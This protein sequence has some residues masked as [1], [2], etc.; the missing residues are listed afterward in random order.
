MKLAYVTAYDADDRSKWSGLGYYLAHAL[1]AQSHTV[2]QI[3]SLR[4]SQP[5]KVWAKKQLYT[6][7]LHQRYLP[8]REPGVVKGY[9]QQASRRLSR[10][11]IDVVFSPGTVP[12]AYLESEHPIVVW[13]DSTFAG[14]VDFYPEFTNLCAESLKN[15]TA[16]EAAAL[17]RAALV[18]YSSEWAAQTARLAYGITPAKLHVVPFGANI[19]V[20]PTLED[21]RRIVAARSQSVC[22]LLFFGIGWARKGGDIAVEVARELNAAGLPTELLVVGSRPRQP[23]P[24]FVR[25][26][27]IGIASPTRLEQLSAVMAESHFLLLPTRADCTPV[28]FSEANA[29]GVPCLATRVGGIESIIRDGVNGATFPRDAT[30]ASYCDYISTRFADWRGYTELA[31]ASFREYQTRLNWDVAGRAVSELLA[32]LSG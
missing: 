7:M 6:R 29:F 10:L 4:V 9:A 28:V 1:K 19:E 3:G 8:D 21:V 15:G 11:A 12:I 18:V 2:E 5:W 14:M 31:L 16:L 22:K 13:T 25:Y 23:T 17:A 24:P 32:N 30:V 26:Q 20:A 27:T